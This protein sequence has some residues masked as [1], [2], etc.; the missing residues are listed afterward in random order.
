MFFRLAAKSLLNR[1]GSVVL[2]ILAMSVS[3]FVLLGVE[4]I[5]TQ[6]KESFNSTVSGVDLIV[7][8]RT[9]S[10]NLLLYSV[11]RI[12]SPTNN[13]DW[14]TYQA[15]ADNSRVAWAIPVSLGDSH[16]GYRVMGT[17]T[18]YFKHFSYGNKRQLD[19][20]EGKPF[21]D[22]FDVVLGSEVARK[23]GYSLGDKIV[24]AHGLGKTSFSLHDDRP[25]K[26]TG[27]LATTG[28][29]VDQTVHISLQ[30]IEAIHIDWQQGV[31]MPGSTITTDQLE[32]LALQPKTI[33]AFMLG[34]NSRMAT[35][36]V[37]RNI[38]NYRKEPLSAILPG[39]ALSELWQMMG[40]MENTLRLISGL[41]L[42]AALLGLSAMMLA[43]IREREHEIHLLR[44]IGASPVFLFLIIEMEALLI[45]LLS[46]L[47]AVSGLYLSLGLSSDF[48]AANFSLHM[49]RSLLSGNKLFFVLLII[50]ATIIAAALP[51]FFAY[52]N[53]RL[54]R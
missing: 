6:T 46:I 24:L 30:G 18:D 49:G 10:L 16:K 28:T 43:S 2:T 36:R 15:I 33:T 14:E 42:M 35:F 54:S 51:S 19:F 47:L 50:G 8:A 39:V 40:L 53:A 23:L 31:K 13:I 3:I 38:N 7:G 52:K 20:T 32:S 27:I 17:S 9:G 34:L 4:H 45:S 26:I 41:I 1:K 11:F 48:L 5:R 44:V 12:G 21:S 37:Q 29:P 25:F 22:L